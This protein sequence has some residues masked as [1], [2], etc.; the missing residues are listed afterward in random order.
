M[1]S[2]SALYTFNFSFVIM[3][4]SRKEEISSLQRYEN[5]RH[6]H[7]SSYWFRSSSSKPMFPPS[8]P[9]SI[10]SKICLRPNEMQ[11]FGWRVDWIGFSHGDRRPS[12]LSEHWTSRLSYRSK[13]DK[14]NILQM[15]IE[16]KCLSPV[17]CQQASPCDRFQCS[18][19]YNLFS[20][21]PLNLGRGLHL[22]VPIPVVDRHFAVKRPLNSHNDVKIRK[23][24]R[25]IKER[26]CKLMPSNV[27]CAA[28]AWQ[29]RLGRPSHSQLVSSWHVKVKVPCR[30]YLWTKL[31]HKKRI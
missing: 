25:D 26:N 2:S 7:S 31:L 3:W 12:W 29:V 10:W 23:Y 27:E 18:P 4:L 1:N 22:P 17:D 5:L 6:L 21:Y 19:S 28:V 20:V 9:S 24:F 16:R 11:L 13:G 30:G 8:R 15:I 14:N